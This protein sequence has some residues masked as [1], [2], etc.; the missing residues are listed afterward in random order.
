[1]NMGVGWTEGISIKD[2]HYLYVL[3]SNSY[4]EIK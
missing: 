3:T 4:L 1:M 2:P